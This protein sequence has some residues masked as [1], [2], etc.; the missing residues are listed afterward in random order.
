[1]GLLKN[2]SSAVLPHT[3]LGAALSAKSYLRA[4]AALPGYVEQIR[5][6]FPEFRFRRARLIDS[7]LENVVVVVDDEWIFRFPR[8]ERR[9]LAFAYELQLL[10]TLRQNTEI[11]LPDYRYV[12]PGARFGGY[13][14]VKGKP[15]DIG[16]FQSLDHAARCQALSQFADFLNALHGLS[17]ARV[18][19]GAAPRRN[20]AKN[21]FV[22]AYLEQQRKF[23]AYRLDADLLGRIDRFYTGY[24]AHQPYPERITHGDIDD[25]HVLLGGQP[26]KLGVIDFGDAAIGDPA[27]D[28]AFLFTLPEWA[29]RY[30]F[31]RY[32]FLAE[33][34]QLPKRAL[35]HSVRFAVSRLWNC[36]RHEGYPRAFAD[37]ANALRLQLALLEA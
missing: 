35:H 33:D 37:T 7:G 11:D 21:D 16:H 27:L 17:P 6:A 19:N 4:R 29:A 3:A 36:L 20:T 28:F 26:G 30:A 23:L 5:E 12:A 15:L 14:M 10:L 1:M 31:A 24:A 8:S 18:L 9:R 34:P 32:A 22:A 2:F 25:H 13:P